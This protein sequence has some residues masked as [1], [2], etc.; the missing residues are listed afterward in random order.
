M[1]TYPQTSPSLTPEIPSYGGG[2]YNDAS[3]TLGYAPE[4]DGMSYSQQSLD[5]DASATY[6]DNGQAT[7]HSYLAPY[8][9]SSAGVIPE[10][11]GNEEAVYSGW[12]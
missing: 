1:S 10:Q 2:L 5:V 11:V 4:L 6:W 12:Y 7:M 3:Y 8:E 9:D